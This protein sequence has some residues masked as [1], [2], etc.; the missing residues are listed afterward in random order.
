MNGRQWKIAESPQLCFR[1]IIHDQIL[2]LVNHNFNNYPTG[3]L[4]CNNRKQ[5]EYS[6]EITAHYE[7]KKHLK[8]SDWRIFN[9]LFISQFKGNGWRRG[10]S[11]RKTSIVIEVANFLHFHL[12]PFARHTIFSMQIHPE[13][14][15]NGK[16]LHTYIISCLG[17]AF[18][19]NCSG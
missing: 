3:K 17:K 4:L 6:E 7:M 16:Y 12:H 10:K 1:H 9:S 11:L 8:K 2:L 14:K 18:Y 5:M 15:F 13:V 19:R